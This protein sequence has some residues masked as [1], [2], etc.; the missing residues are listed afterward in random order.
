MPY[1]H[2][3]DYEDS[4]GRLREI[5][6]E[7]IGS[8]GKLAAVHKIQS[9]HPETIV[10]H[11]DLYMKI[12]FGK[13]PLRRYQREMIAVIVSVYN[14]CPY[15][16][17]HHG[18]A[19][20]FFWKDEEKVNRLIKDYVSVDLSGMDLLLCR[21]AHLLTQ[22]P[23]FPKKEE[24]LDQLRQEGLSDRGILDATLVIA[25]FNFVNRIVLG[26]GVEIESDGGGGYR[27]D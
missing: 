25:Y 21:L 1:I 6:D 26:L 14:D 27:Y 18:E 12:L 3:I 15:C 20:Q 17:R 4:E 13:S 5:Y 22:D 16:I 23:N 8:R 7:L 10:A 2:V 24:L 9:L 19:L 11:M